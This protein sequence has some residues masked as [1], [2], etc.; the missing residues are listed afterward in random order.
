M[1]SSKAPCEIT[2]RSP[3]HTLHAHKRRDLVVA[4]VYC[5][6]YDLSC[7]SG[8]HLGGRVRASTLSVCVISG[9]A[10]LHLLLYGLVT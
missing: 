7:I 10:D 8:R 2:V 9:C 1:V 5:G 3:L 6:E 4:M